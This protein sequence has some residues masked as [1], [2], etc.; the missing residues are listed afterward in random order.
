LA[1]ALDGNSVLNKAE[2]NCLRATL[3][4]STPSVPILAS[5]RYFYTC[6]LNGVPFVYSDGSTATHLKPTFWIK[7]VQFRAR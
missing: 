1:E 4:W 5:L 7:L 2:R 3:I 6:G